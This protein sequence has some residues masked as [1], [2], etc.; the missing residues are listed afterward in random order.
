[1]V[2]LESVSKRF[3]LR[4]HHKKVKIK[5]KTTSINEINR[6]I[7]FVQRKL[8][9]KFQKKAKILYNVKKTSE[10]IPH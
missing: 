2:S 6:K 3:F 9:E 10:E 1:V 8:V 4:E 5:M 7:K